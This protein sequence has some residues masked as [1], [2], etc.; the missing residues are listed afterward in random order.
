MERDSPAATSCRRFTGAAQ[1]AVVPD[2]LLGVITA[3]LANDALPTD[4]EFDDL[5]AFLDSCQPE[6]GLPIDAIDGM[7]AA[8][9]CG[10]DSIMPSEWMPA[11]W[12][13]TL[14]EYESKAQAQKIMD[15]LMKWYN[16]VAAEITSG[17][18]QP[19]MAVWEVEGS[20]EEVEYPEDW[21]LGFMEGMKFRAAAWEARA[22]NDA[23]LMEMLESIVTVAESTDDFAR[24]LLDTRV[25][26]R[27]I[28]RITD[29]VIDMRDYWQQQRPI[30]QRG[31][32]PAEK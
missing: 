32:A 9:I 14:P 5:E 27:V 12:R 22:K 1:V 15:T 21:C 16:S 3:M 17:T 4:E 10:P 23:E 2:G 30:E 11:V 24:S 6:P 26:R 18:Y 7:L 20:V 29:A 13:N 31:S 28:R 8:I 19:M 25:R